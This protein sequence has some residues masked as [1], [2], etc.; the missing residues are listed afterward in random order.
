MIKDNIENTKN[1]ETLS[2]NIR[3]GFEWINANNLK[4]MPDGRYDINDNVYANLQTYNTKEDALFEAH[5]EYM[6]I[7]YMIEGSEKCGICSYNNCTTE[8]EYS[9]EKDIEFLK[10][11]KFEYLTLNEG[12][13]FIFF[14]NDAHKPA[15]N[16][17]ISQSVKKVVIKAHI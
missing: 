16:N 13:F 10:A 8:A 6:D 9:K 2:E 17:K 4:D 12:E 14:P 1:Y 3:V 15:L 11:E 5:R 7:Q